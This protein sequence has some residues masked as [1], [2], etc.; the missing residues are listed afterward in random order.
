MNQDLAGIGYFIPLNITKF[1]V[2]EWRLE[3]LTYAKNGID[4][5]HIDWWESSLIQ[6]L[7]TELDIRVDNATTS[8]RKQTGLKYRHDLLKN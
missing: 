6:R 1:Q 8:N 3:T 2:T 7:L 4:I 5:Q